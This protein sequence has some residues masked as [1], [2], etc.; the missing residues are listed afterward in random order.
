M[1]TRGTRRCSNPTHSG[2]PHPGTA[3]DTAGARLAQHRVGGSGAPGA[4]AGR[5]HPGEG[6]HGL[7]RALGHHAVHPAARVVVAWTAVRSVDRRGRG[8]VGDRPPLRST[9]D[10]VAPASASPSSREARTGGMSA[11]ILGVGTEILLG[12]IC[13]NNA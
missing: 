9:S 13:N 10:T 11:E 6:T 4:V 3:P 8:H 2:D 12:Q 5:A 7:L 1:P